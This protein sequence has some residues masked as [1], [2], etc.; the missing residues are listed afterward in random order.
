MINFSLK[1]KKREPQYPSVGYSYG[2]QRTD[3]DPN[4]NNQEEHGSMI[5]TFSHDQ[6]TEPIIT[7]PEKSM[8][9]TK[10]YQSG[11]KDYESSDT[12]QTQMTRIKTVSG[13]NSDAENI[14]EL[15]KQSNTIQY[16]LG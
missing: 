2:V 13:S 15:L 16:K 12:E 14:V 1:K 4:D 5:P 8:K 7:I 3:D 9:S 6:I 11:P 10:S